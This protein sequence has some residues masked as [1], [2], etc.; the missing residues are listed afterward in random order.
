[1]KVIIFGATGMVGGEVLDQCLLNNQIQQVITIG[2]RATGVSHP[3]LQEILHHNFLDYTSLE[4]E[5]SQAN[6]CFYCLGVYQTQVPKDKFWEITVDYLNS[7]IRVLEKVNPK[8]I[9]CLFSAQG[10][11]P[12]ERSPILF[13]KVKGRA[14]R[15]LSESRILTKYIFRPGFINPVNKISGPM[16]FVRIFRGF[17]KL[18][19]GIGIDASVLGRVMV[20]VGL[21]GYK[22]NVLKNRDLRAVAKK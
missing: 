11:D 18:F 5:L 20:K 10:A 17:Y 22:K 14:E 6:I 12:K 15:K 9:F 8:I 1:M 13:A 4:S 21:S 16:A 7:L 2:R 3:K 19:P